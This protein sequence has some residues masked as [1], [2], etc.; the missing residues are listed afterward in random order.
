MA[1]IFQ[2]T[3]SDA[4]SWMKIYELRLIFHS[5]SFVLKGL[6][7]NIPALVQIM[8][9]RQSGDKPLSEPMMVSLLTHICVTRPQW[10]IQSNHCNS[11]EDEVPVDIIY[12]YPNFKW[13]VVSWK[14]W[15]VTRIVAPNH[16]LRMRGI[17]STDVSESGLESKSLLKPYS[18]SICTLKLSWM[19]LWS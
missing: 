5:L 12:G 2:T 8:A 19:I 14:S 16:L 7:D 13:V 10:V 9:W 17:Q 6:I 18:N 3:F 15:E 4:F 1:A 11:F